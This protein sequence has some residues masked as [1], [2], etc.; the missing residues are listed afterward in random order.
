M[1]SQ[2]E[3]VYTTKLLKDED[4]YELYEHL[5]WN[6]FLKLSPEKL[7]IAMQQSWLVIY[8]YINHQLVGTGRVV[9]DGVINAYL[10]GLGVREEYRNNGIGTEVSKRLVEA[11]VRHQLHTQFFCEQELV[12]F[13]EK[14][15]FKVFAVG[16]K[17]NE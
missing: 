16:M 3:V 4:L 17:V 15:N 10:C 6:N 2:M 7:L 9:S 14:L 12:P 1:V 13:Y 8:A 5:T 11:C